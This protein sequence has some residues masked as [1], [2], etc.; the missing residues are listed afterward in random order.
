LNKLSQEKSRKKFFIGNKRIFD[1][2]LLGILALALVFA[3]W[4]VFYT[5][6][7]DSL[8]TAVSMS[9]TEEKISRLLSEIEGVGEAEVMIGENEEGISGVVVVCEGANNFQVVIDIREAVAAAL[10]TKENRIKIYL[11]KE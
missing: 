8:E 4:K 3:T 7:T 10:G 1:V 11:K 2:L 9:E 6:D 5:E